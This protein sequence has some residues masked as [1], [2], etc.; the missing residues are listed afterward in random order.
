M[1][2]VGTILVWLTWGTSAI[3]LV[4]S[5]LALAAIV[6]HRDILYQKKHADFLE[7]RERVRRKLKGGSA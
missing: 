4:L 5:L 3:G 2:I 1:E 7:Q 6:K